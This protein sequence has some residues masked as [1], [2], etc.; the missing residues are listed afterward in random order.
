MKSSFNKK[1][2]IKYKY[3]YKYLLLKKML[4]GEPLEQLNIGIG[5]NSTRNTYDKELLPRYA[6]PDTPTINR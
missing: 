5:L 3:K 2:Y 4:G 1:K 6:N